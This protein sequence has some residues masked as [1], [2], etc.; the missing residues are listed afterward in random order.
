MEAGNNELKE[1]AL[2]PLKQKLIYNLF[3][4]L[5]FRALPDAAHNVPVRFMKLRAIFAFSSSPLK[6]NFIIVSAATDKSKLL[7]S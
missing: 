4:T 1:S 5:T 7:C 6:I 2:S 3:S